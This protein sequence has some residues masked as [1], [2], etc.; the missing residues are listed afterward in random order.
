MAHRNARTTVRVRSE[1]VEMVKRG[2]SVASAAAA[3]GMSRQTAYKWLK[4]HASGEGLEDRSSRPRR[5]PRLSGPAV[6]ALVLGERQRT[7]DGPAVIAGRLGLVRSTVWN[8]LR[9]AGVSRLPR[10]PKEPIVRYERA[11]PGELLHIDIK[12]LPRIG[13]V[14]GHRAT[15]D[16]RTTNRKAQKGTGYTYVH[17]AIDDRTRLKYVEE[18]NTQQAVDAVAFLRRAYS[19]YASMGIRIERTLTDNGPCYRSDDWQAACIRLRIKPRYTRA[20]RPQTNGKAERAIRTMLAGWAYGPTYQNNNERSSSLT[21]YV[22]WYNTRRYHTAINATPWQR[23][24]SDLQA[25]N[26]LS[27]H[28]S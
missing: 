3:C 26:N 1:L 25:V 12:R 11:R 4:R 20:Y 8:I 24:A 28:Y 19:W 9:R 16:R 18:L 2:L 23:A 17:V 22:D 6:V 27:E 7:G 14:P 13:S 21:A 15:G 5:M 10:E